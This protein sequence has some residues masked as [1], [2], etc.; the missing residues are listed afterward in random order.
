VLPCPTTSALP[1][2]ARNFST[3]GR[4]SFAEITVGLTAHLSLSVPQF[5]RALEFRNEH[6]PNL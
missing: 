1:F 3:S 2:N 5:L 4:I 6:G